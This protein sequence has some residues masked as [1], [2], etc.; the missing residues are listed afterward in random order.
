MALID[1]NEKLLTQ[2]AVEYS[3]PE[4]KLACEKCLTVIPVE[5][6]GGKFP[7]REAF[8]PQLLDTTAGI[9]S[10]AP[11]FIE[12]HRIREGVFRVKSHRLKTL[13]P[14]EEV[15]ALNAIG[16][17]DY[18]VERIKELKTSLLLE[19][20]YNFVQLLAGTSNKTTPSVKWNGQNPTI[21]KDLADAINAFKDNAKV[22]PNKLIIPQKVWDVMVMD[23]TL[24]QIF[25]LIPNRKE[26]NLDIATI[27][28]Q[29]FDTIQEIIIVDASI[30]LKKNSAP[31]DIWGDDVYLLY[32]VPRGNKR[33]FTAVGIFLYEDW[34]I[35]RVDSYDPEGEYIILSSKYDIQVICENAIYKLEN[36][37][38]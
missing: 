1:L 34:K 37:L 28:S 4:F 16:I 2:F 21:E 31:V 32:T 3:P 38:S 15:E 33:T 25:T 11:L 14:K 17:N 19:K 18:A 10:E 27:L 8:V 30:Q 29:R 20:E 36:V 22:Y 9:Y 7:V 23:P 5:D 26:Q 13:I 6:L 35:K 24:R 12:D